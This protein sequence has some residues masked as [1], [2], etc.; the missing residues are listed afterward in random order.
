MKT[1]S[2][3]RADSSGS[4]PPAS[5]IS[6]RRVPAPRFSGHYAQ[7]PFPII[8]RH[9]A[10]IDLGGRTSHFIAFEVSETELEVLE[11]GC[12]TPDIDQWVKYLK[13]HGVTTVAMEATSVY[14]IPVY[15]ALETAGLEV[16]LV[17]PSHAKNVPGRAKDD[18]LDACWLQKLHK[19]GLLTASFRPSEDIRPLQSFWRQRTIQVHLCADTLRRQQK[20]LDMMN[21]RPHKLLS[22]L[23]GLT[24]Q[25]IVDAIV[26]GERDPVVLASYRDK[27][28]HCTEE[29]LQA[30]LTGHYQDHLVFMLKQNRISYIFHHAQIAE[31]DAQ[32]QQH[33]SNMIPLS[34]EEIEEAIRS[35]SHP[36]DPAKHGPSYN[37]KAMVHLFLNVDPTMIPGIGGLIALGLLSELG[38]D[39]DKWK[40]DKHF[41]SYLGIAPVQKVSGGKKLSSRTRPGIHPAAKL[42]L[43][44]ATAVMRSDNDCGA[45]YRSKA[46]F[47]GKQKALFA[48]AYRIAR[49]YYHLLKDGVEYVEIGAQNNEAQRQKQEEAKFRKKAKRFGYELVKIK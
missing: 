11:V 13:F 9:A 3:E 45:F 4:V 32:I 12:M 34:N 16:I 29:E 14:W 21:L 6:Q 31:I 1:N 39:M 18:K 27:H 40:T 8:H 7:E 23:A 47:I 37:V 36:V 26:D 42:F 46:V 43:Q 35:D 25:R 10:G 5:T 19:Y 49:V 15:D 28:C 22:D 44:A 38:Y 48:T 17:N 24:G 20:A 41:G 30:A 33:L 2:R